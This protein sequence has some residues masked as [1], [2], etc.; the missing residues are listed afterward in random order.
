MERMHALKRE[1][2]ITL[3]WID[4]TKQRIVEEDRKAKE[5][6]NLFD[7]VMDLISYNSN[8]E[9]ARM[10][11]RVNDEIDRAMAAADWDKLK[12]DIEKIL[13]GEIK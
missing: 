8:A 6:R 2:D 1:I 9:V 3:N 5:G 4:E 10:T 7:A 11:E 13:T 12:A